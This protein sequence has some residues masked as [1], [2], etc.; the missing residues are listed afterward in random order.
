MRATLKAVAAAAVTA[1]LLAACGSSETPEPGATGGAAN[2]VKVGVIPIVDVAPL[3][4]GIKQGFF[5]ERGMNVTTEAGQGGAAI[6]PGVVSGQFQFGFSNVTSLIIARSKG[7][8]LKMISEMLGH[9][10]IT[11]T[12]DVYAHVLAPA[13]DDVA[14]AMDRAIAG[15]APA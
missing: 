6:V 10:S 9:S 7:V 11:V 15:K 3:Y 14:A 1:V 2:N 12:A 8:P 5:S 4:L 13:K